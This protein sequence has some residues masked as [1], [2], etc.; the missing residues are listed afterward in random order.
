MTTAQ[1]LARPLPL[2]LLVLAGMA[3]ALGGALVFEHVFGYIP[4]QLCLQ[5]REPYYLGL[6]FAALAVAGLALGWPEAAWRGFLLVAG[7]CLVATLALGFYHAGAEWGFWVGP[8]D[9]GAG[10]GAL[11]TSAEGLL[12]ALETTKPPSCT[13]AAGRFLGLSFAGWNVVAATVLAVL[14]FRAATPRRLFERAH[15]P[16]LGQTQPDARP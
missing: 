16:N 4:C 1:A 6:P 5:Q 2:A 9:C 14:A 8:A 11:P 7:A 15:A 12:S 13:E 3:A 10:G